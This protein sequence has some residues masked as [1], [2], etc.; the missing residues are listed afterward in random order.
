MDAIKLTELFAAVDQH[1]KA[2]LIHEVKQA[3]IKDVCIERD[4]NGLILTYSFVCTGPFVTLDKLA[5][6]NT[7]ANKF[8]RK[9]IMDKLVEAYQKQTL[10]EWMNLIK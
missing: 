9:I 10:T 3:G 1:A 7:E 4:S 6:G 2:G 8:T 5:I